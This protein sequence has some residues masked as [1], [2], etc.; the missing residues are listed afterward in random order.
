MN[1]T[2]SLQRE[3]LRDNFDPDSSKH[4][5]NAQKNKIARLN[6]VDNAFS[7]DKPKALKGKHILIVDDVM[8]SGATMEACAIPILEIEGTRVSM[9]TLAIALS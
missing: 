5:S 1:Q 2:K 8:T 6:N 7:V 9:V 3:V 4:A